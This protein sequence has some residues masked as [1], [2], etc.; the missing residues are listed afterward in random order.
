MTDYI[1]RGQGQMDLRPYIGKNILPMGG[2]TP[3]QD[4][5]CGEVP[6]DAQGYSA[7][8]GF[9]EQ[10]MQQMC[11]GSK[12]IMIEYNCEVTDEHGKQRS[13]AGKKPGHRGAQPVIACHHVLN[14]EPEHPDGVEF[15]PFSRGSA[16]GMFLCPS[17][18]RALERHRLNLGTDVSMKC[19]KCVLEKIM[20]I[21]KYHPGKLVNLI[22]K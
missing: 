18:V 9:Y 11:G 4:P 13:V 19:S 5:F 22:A 15:A 2:E 17:C 10:K 20:E 6:D 3:E 8:R 14:Q 16:G 21:G 12:F 7:Y 1:D